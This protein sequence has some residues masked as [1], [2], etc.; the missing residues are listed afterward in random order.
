MDE[1][2]CTRC[3]GSGM[4]VKQN[5]DGSVQWQDCYACRGNGKQ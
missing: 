1:E 4:L 5:P 3:G 2:K